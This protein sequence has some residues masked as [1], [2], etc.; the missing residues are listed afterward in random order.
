MQALA[1]LALQEAQRRPPRP[2]RPTCATALVAGLE[3]AH[4]ASVARFRDDEVITTDGP[5]AEG[6]E[7]V[8][9]LTIVAAADFDSAVEWGRKA[10]AACRTGVEVRQLH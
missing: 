5:Y 10:G 7:H 6:K 9:G 4:A 8:G 3:L 1:Q 2:A